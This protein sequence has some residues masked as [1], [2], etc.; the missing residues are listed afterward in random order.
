LV[1]LHGRERRR[2][3]ARFRLA[4]ARIAGVAVPLAA[5]RHHCLEDSVA[6]LALAVLDGVLPSD[7][8]PS[9]L[10]E[11]RRDGEVGLVAQLLWQLIKRLAQSDGHNGRK[12]ERE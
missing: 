11:E 1:R 6:A 9:P 3:H 5:P 10:L 7:A 12:P 4:R 2:L 8:R